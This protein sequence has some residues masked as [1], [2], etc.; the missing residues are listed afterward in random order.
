[1]SLVVNIEDNLIIFTL[2]RWPLCCTD[3]C[4]CYSV[5]QR[6]LSTVQQLQNYNLWNYRALFLK[7]G[8][9][10]YRCS[11]YSGTQHN[12]VDIN[13]NNILKHTRS[14]HKENG[15][16]WRKQ[17]QETDFFYFMPKDKEDNYFVLSQFFLTVL[18]F[19]KAWQDLQ[20]IFILQTNVKCS[21][22]G[23]STTFTH[24]KVSPAL[25]STTAYV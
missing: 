12:F 8:G 21:L 23:N 19:S 22:K 2:D 9:G 6:R 1:M 24:Q 14:Q 20:L 25:S 13:Q 10:V 5:L 3:R 16:K 15:A 7:N 17:D 4:N 11:M 18:F